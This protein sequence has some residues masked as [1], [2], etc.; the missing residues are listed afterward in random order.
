MHKVPHQAQISQPPPHNEEELEKQQLSRSMNVSNILNQSLDPQR[1][2]NNLIQ[3]TDSPSKLREKPNFNDKRT[4]QLN[5][6]YIDNNP[7]G[8]QAAAYLLAQPT[9]TSK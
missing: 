3:S 6:N 9:N 8:S 1:L 7:N 5:N 2:K 4:T